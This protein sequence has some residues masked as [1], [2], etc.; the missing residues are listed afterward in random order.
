MG[1]IHC[2]GLRRLYQGAPFTTDER[3][4]RGDHGALHRRDDV[5]ALRD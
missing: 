1:Q 3:V 2:D 4:N 5:T